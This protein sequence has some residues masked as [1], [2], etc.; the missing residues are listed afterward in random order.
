MYL[1]MVFKEIDKVII[2][3]LILFLQTLMNV[4]RIMEGV[5]KPVTT[6]QVHTTVS[7]MMAMGGPQMT[8]ARPAMVCT[9][10]HCGFIIR[11]L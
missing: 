8:M 3:I 4:Q 5:L 6:Q 1:S 10:T 2:K 7:A 11:A 9:C